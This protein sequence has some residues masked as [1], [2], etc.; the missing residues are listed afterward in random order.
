LSDVL[1][2]RFL[3]R[4]TACQFLESGESG[5]VSRGILRRPGSAI[6]PF[7]LKDDMLKES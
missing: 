4:L 5:S 6:V 2:M 7:S 3:A 1:I